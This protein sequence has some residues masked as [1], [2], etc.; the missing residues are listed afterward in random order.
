M[1]QLLTTDIGHPHVEKLIAV[2]T[3]LFRVSDDKGQF[4]RNYAR[5]FPKVGAQMELLPERP[6]EI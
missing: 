5:A 1:A 2:N 6:K 4:W 3:M